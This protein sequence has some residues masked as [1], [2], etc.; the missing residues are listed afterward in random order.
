MPEQL[1]FSQTFEGLIRALGDKLDAVAARQLGEVGLDVYGK[2]LPAYP[3]KVWTDSLRVSAK[4]LC[5]DAPEEV[6]LFELGRRF[7]HGFE[8]TLLGRGTLA[9]ARVLGPKRSLQR[10]TRNF[11]NGNN[12]T[13]TRMVELG[14]GKFELWCSRVVTVEF[15]RG[16]IAAGL[17]VSGAK[18]P[19]VETAA[20]DPEGTTY[21]I[22]WDEG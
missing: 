5:P 1:V 3:S 20:T 17:E 14:P 12:Y 22:T 15:I 21:R 4:V 8:E 18:H 7:I 9:L 19:K 13:E 6:G 16:M 2:L 10:M 11:R